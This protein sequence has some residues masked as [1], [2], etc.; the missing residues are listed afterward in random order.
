MLVSKKGHER[1][2]KA[3]PDSRASLAKDKKQ[4][5]KRQEE[6]GEKC[7]DRETVGMGGNKATRGKHSTKRKTGGNK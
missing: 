2:E 4:K 7:E 1:S 5:T 3:S 6:M